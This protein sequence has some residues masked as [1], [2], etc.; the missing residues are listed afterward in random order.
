[1]IVRSPLQSRGARRRNS[2]S[3]RPGGQRGAIA[4]GA[5]RSRGAQAS[6]T[7]CFDQTRKRQGAWSRGTPVIGW[8]SVRVPELRSAPVGSRS[9]PVGERLEGEQV[10]RAGPL[11]TSGWG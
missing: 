1:M 11:A 4:F 5:K 3:G 8:R 9:I 10:R 6:R 2:E 7:L